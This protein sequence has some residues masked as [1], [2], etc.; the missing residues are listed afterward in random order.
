M[1]RSTT[2]NK[3]TVI[4][5]EFANLSYYEDSDKIVYKEKGISRILIILSIISA[6]II[7][8][9]FTLPRSIL[10]QYLFAGLIGPIIGFIALFVLPKIEMQFHRKLKELSICSKGIISKNR[11][12]NWDE[13]ELGIGHIPGRIS[14]IKID[15]YYKTTGQAINSIAMGR[16]NDKLQA[17]IE[18]LNDFM[19][20]RPIK[21]HYYIEKKADK[22]PVKED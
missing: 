19:S 14:V 18:F 21:E 17:C 22:P 4:P 20:G 12:Y 15:I 11:V 9:S 10:F 3:T 16:N 6:V 5:S 7:I 1:I 8:P 13:L 2:N